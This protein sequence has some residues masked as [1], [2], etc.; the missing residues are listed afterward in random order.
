MIHWKI[1]RE[2]APFH[3]DASHVGPY[4][5]DG[6]N[7]C[8]WAA[9]TEIEQLRAEIDRLR[10]EIDRLREG[11]N[12][13]ATDLHLPQPMSDETAA[14]QVS[15]GELM[16]QQ[17][18]TRMVAGAY[19]DGNPNAAARHIASQTAQAQRMSVEQT[20]AA[21]DVLAERRR[22][23]EV[24]GWTAEHD[25]DHALGEIAALATFYAMPDGAREWDATSTGYGRTLGAAMLPEGWTAR[26]GT[27]RRRDLVK[28]G[29]LIIAEIE[30]LDRAAAKERK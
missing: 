17:R 12:S 19:P 14:Q 3:P 10:A 11:L 25:D 2:Y 1:G 22:Q 15:L 7:A 13:H 5:R 20:Q 16:R 28:A 29:A 8:Y 4:Y 30:R 18:A 27:D 6:W 21:I 9:D 26:A 23:V 24:E